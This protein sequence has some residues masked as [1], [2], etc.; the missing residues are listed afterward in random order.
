MFGDILINFSLAYKNENSQI[1]I[2]DFQKIAKRYVFNGNFIKDFLI[3]LPVSPL[4]SKKYPKIR[5]LQII[6]FV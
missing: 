4:L 5:F 3:W 2:T 1:L 6:K